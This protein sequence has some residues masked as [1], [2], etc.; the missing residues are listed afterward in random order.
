[1]NIPNIE[2]LDAI[3]AECKAIVRTRARISAGVAIIPIPLADIG[4]DAALIRG[5]IS[6][7]NQKFGLT[8]AQIERLEPQIRKE[9]LAAVAGVGSGLIGRIISK[10][11]IMHIFKKIGSRV[12]T[13]SVA[14]YLPV[15][16]SAVAATVSFGAIKMLGDSHIEDCYAV[17][18]QAAFRLP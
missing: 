6:A 18:K 2:K 17:A 3:R 13:K 12:A 4:V 9:V 16:G 5:M 8:P 10:K 15:L 7:I 14:K 11:L 1:M